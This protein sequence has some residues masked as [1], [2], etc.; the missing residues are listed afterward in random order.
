MTTIP[1]IGWGP[2]AAFFVASA[3]IGV[4]AG[5]LAGQSGP[6]ANVLAAVLPVVISGAG[7]ALVVLHLKSR[8]P[9]TPRDYYITAF[10]VILFTMSL[11]AGSHTGR[12]AR[13]YAETIAYE[14]S[15]EIR[16]K[17]ERSRR[18]TLIQFLQ[19]C[20][21][22]EFVINR[23]RHALGLPPILTAVICA[24]SRSSSSSRGESGT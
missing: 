22:Q 14:Q 4:S 11:L 5:Y 1:S 21:R 9:P 24:A 23:G 16:L 15:L 2:I 13:D 12:W 10:A 7:G 6:D 18:E 19:R 20:S 3:A 17:L 8:A